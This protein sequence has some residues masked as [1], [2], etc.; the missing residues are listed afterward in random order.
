MQN[1]ISVIVPVY[2]VEKYLDACVTSIVNQTYQNLEIILVDDGSPDNC[3]AICDEWATKDSRIKVI[4]KKNGGLSDARNAGMAIATGE[5]IGFVDS[6]DVLSPDMYR[7]LYELVEQHAADVAQCKMYL[8]S[9][10]PFSG[11]PVSE[12]QNVNVFSAEEAISDLL[13]GHTI[14]V[15][16]PN[17]LVK[18]EIAKTVLFEV[19]RINED[20]LWT[21]RV[22]AKSKKIVTTDT[23]LYGYYQ[24][25]GSI[26]NSQY[27]EKRFD[28]LYSL[29][30]RAKEV[31]NDFPSLYPVAL[32]NYVGGCMYHYQTICRLPQKSA[33]K[34]YKK[35]IHK[36]FC[37]SD[38]KTVFRVT[39]PEYR[40]WYF[41]FRFF[42]DIT[43]KIRIRL[44]IGL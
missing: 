8:F 33:Y 34:Y 10:L 32:K 17:L 35:L 13:S 18:S 43:C 24:R 5:Y 12:F 27:T 16:C 36:R 40:I 28:A 6:D 29:E 22:F 14:N 39:S 21:Y 42:P 41:L 1:L 3:P 20:V 38:L 25:P 26:M 2:K 37:E 7:V 4:H 11:F 19:N 44:K 9:D 30:Q 31:R 15:T 23:F